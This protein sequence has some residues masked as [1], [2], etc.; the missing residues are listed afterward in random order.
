MKPKAKTGVSRLILCDPVCVFPYGHNVAAMENYRTF[1][2]PYFD[3]VIC[4]GCRELPADIAAAR[5]IERAY[6]YYYNDAMPLPG[7]DERN[8]IPLRHPDKVKAAQADLNALL[9]RHEVTGHDT[10]CFPSVDFY[11]L[12]A[13]ADCT[14][15]LIAAGRPKV[16]LRLI[17]VMENAT[18]GTYAKP[19]NVVLALIA[20][21]RT[22][23]IPLKIAAE[24]PRYADFL[25][26]QLDCPVPVA[27]NIETH[28]QLPLPE[29]GRFTV[30]CPGS[31]RYDKG[32]LN[33]L[34]IFT[35]VRQRDPDLKIRFQTQVLPDHELK[36]HLAY[37]ARLYALPGV[38]ILPSQVSAGQI[39]EMFA[40]ADLVLL[41]YA[42]DVYE[43]RGSAVL[44]EAMC[45]GRHALALDG[46]AFVD[47]M[48]FFGGGAACNSL[49]EMADR[50]I[51]YSRRSPMLRFSQA[52]QARDRFVRD[53]SASYRDWV[54]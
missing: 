45:T 36:H 24:T 7:S 3:K 37:L 20:R 35:S 53:L 27:A 31:A 46:P 10:L 50:V 40:A 12:Q 11:S 32:F 13:L 14:D 22:A 38:T 9:K 5:G 16:M 21:L 2:G 8:D 1:L 51:E 39:K 18:S 49:S 23:G 33:L 29:T 43:Y 30:I 48:R 19:M 54:M 26:M 4:I 44:I 52:R 15:T 47:Q 28:E 41:P 42:A 25:A 34:E 6:S 17:G